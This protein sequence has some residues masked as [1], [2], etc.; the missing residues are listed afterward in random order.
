MTNI[1]EDSLPLT[2]GKYKG[3]SPNDI[4]EHDPRYV[5]WLYE[6]IQPPVVSRALAV[7]C[8]QTA[9]DEDSDWYDR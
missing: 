4:S 6:N 7:E 1:D 8:E 2:F 5:V 3:E 9:E